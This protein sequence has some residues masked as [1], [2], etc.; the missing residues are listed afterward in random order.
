MAVINIIVTLAVPLL[1]A[2]GYGL[3]CGFQHRRKI[4]ELRKQ[5]IVRPSYRLPGAVYANYISACRRSGTGSLAI[6]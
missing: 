5:G 2:I 6:C 3:Y 1:T 4:N